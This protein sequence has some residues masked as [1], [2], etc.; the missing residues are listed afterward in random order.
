MLWGARTSASR[1]ASNAPCAVIVASGVFPS[2]G[3]LTALY[4]DRTR[5]S[6]SYSRYSP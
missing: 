1:I 4:R 6:Y 5:V 3:P 2:H